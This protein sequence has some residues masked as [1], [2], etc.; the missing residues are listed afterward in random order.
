MAMALTMGAD[1]ICGST[2]PRDFHRDAVL[3]PMS[4]ESFEQTGAEVRPH[5]PNRKRR[6]QG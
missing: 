1:F 5:R 4:A 3:V 6:R 2:D